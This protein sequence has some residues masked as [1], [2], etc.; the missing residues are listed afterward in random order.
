MTASGW[1]RLPQIRPG[2][3]SENAWPGLAVPRA[4]VTSF[5]TCHP[6]FPRP[7][8][9]SL[10]VPSTLRTRPRRTSRRARQVTGPGVIDTAA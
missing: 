6:V 4:D 8:E 9:V 10:L 1:V 7:R 5:V 2:V 3:V